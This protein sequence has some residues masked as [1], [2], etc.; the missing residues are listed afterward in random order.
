VSF[1]ELWIYLENKLSF[2]KGKKAKQ[3]ATEEY[4]QT[5]RADQTNDKKKKKKNEKKPNENDN[6]NNKQLDPERLESRP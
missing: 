5:F 6:N 3:K 1:L 2:P 4:K